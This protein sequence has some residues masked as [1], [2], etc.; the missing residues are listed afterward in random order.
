MNYNYNKQKAIDALAKRYTAQLMPPALFFNHNPKRDKPLFGTPP[1]ARSGLKIEKGWPTMKAGLIGNII[2]QSREMA[3]NSCA[4]LN[5]G[6]L[7]GNTGGK[8]S[9]W[10]V[11]RVEVY[12]QWW[13]PR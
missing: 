11:V 8:V 1:R 5:R 13:T 7:P 9:R 3:R 2:Y 10:R 12:T 6:Q 4:M